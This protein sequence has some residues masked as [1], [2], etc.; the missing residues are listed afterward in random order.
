MKTTTQEIVKRK[1]PVDNQLN[2]ITVLG[3]GVAAVSTVAAVGVIGLP[4]FAVTAA[5]LFGVHL[6]RSFRK[7]KS[8]HA[9]FDDIGENLA[10]EQEDRDEIE[11]WIDWGSYQFD[12]IEPDVSV[13]ETF[14]QLLCFRP[15]KS[16]FRTDG[17]TTATYLNGYVVV[18]EE[19]SD[20]EL[21]ERNFRHA[22]N[23]KDDNFEIIREWVFSDY[24]DEL[25]KRLEQKTEK[26]KK[27]KG[28][29]EKK[30]AV[31]KKEFINS[32]YEN[33]RSEARL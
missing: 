9:E 25:I 10:L 26:L 15:V 16:G 7:A 29:S 20:V 19:L 22:F 2:A 1:V 5:L 23:G 8:I 11:G 31:A 24:K 21:F 17:N 3:V 4:G 33:K 30:I 32:V 28:D 27:S 14:S 13:R 18:S 12:A 6:V